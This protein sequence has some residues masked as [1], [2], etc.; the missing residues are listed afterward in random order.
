MSDPTAPL[1]T[2]AIILP[3]LA[4][5]SWIFCVPALFWQFRQGNIA[6]G[7]LIN[8]FNSI[9][10]LIWPRD[11]LDEWWS[12]NVWCDINVRL[13]IG[14]IAGTTASAA[15][16]VRK[17]AR[18]MD[19]RS[20]TVS[21]SKSS[22]RREQFLE[23]A[24]CWG[25]PLVLI[26][27]YYVVQPVRYMLYTIQGCLNAYDTSWPSVVLNFM[28]APITTL[29]AAV[30]AGKSPLPSSPTISYFLLTPT[31][32]ILTYRLYRYRR[33][34]ARLVA[35]RNTTK[36]R[37]V[38]L[39]LICLIVI[40]VYL[41]YTTW[42][43]TNL[44]AAT[45]GHDAYSWNR[46]HDP[47]TFNTISKVAMYGN[48]P[49]DKWG[50]V[51]TGYV[52]FFVF[53]TGADAWKLYRQM[54]LTV[55]LGKWFPGLYATRESGAVTPRS[56]ATWRDSVTS[57]AKSVFQSRSGSMTNS[58]VGGTSRNDSVGMAEMSQLR[59]VSTEDPM[60]DQTSST[61]SSWLSKIFTR[62]SVPHAVLP[63]FTHRAHLTPESTVTR[64]K[65]WAL[66]GD[67]PDFTAH[68]SATAHGAGE[69]E[70]IHVF[71]EMRFEVRMTRWSRSGSRMMTCSDVHEG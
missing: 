71:R 59:Q 48:V 24:W 18:V 19:T 51:A 69:T 27:V 57:R 10:P 9:N 56:F 32:G 25:Y 17:L 38:R 40:L 47:A 8:F 42:L 61:R 13:Q 41:P 53:G 44:I 36:S 31:P 52:L 43:L 22:K 66:R 20:L 39:F 21:T 29:V 34:F 11:N 6:A 50:Q 1:Y 12:G 16:I 58:T 30:Y 60:L 26:L 28:W 37:F 62:Q 7:S 23:V 64:S 15:M 67:A 70:G 54:A 14:A 4:F 49:V 5:P 63:M 2:A 68:V 46:I 55:G 45:R 3:I 33:E 35:A 65:D